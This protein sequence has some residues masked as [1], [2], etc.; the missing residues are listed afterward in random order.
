[1]VPGREAFGGEEG[2]VELE[3]A[4]RDDRCG[5]QPRLSAVERVERGGDAVNVHG[6]QRS[7]DYHLCP[8][9]R[10]SSAGKYVDRREPRMK[11]L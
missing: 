5:V 2:D 6:A 8:C 7:Y 9:G 11:Y 1:M 3:E 10:A 4:G